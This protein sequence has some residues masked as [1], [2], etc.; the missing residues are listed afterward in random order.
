MGRKVLITG[1]AGFIA[2]HVADAHLAAG[3]RVTIL[4]DLSSGRRENI[5]KGAE[6]VHGDIRS[7]EARALLAS[8]GFNVL[9]HHAAQI[10]VRHSVADPVADSGINIVGLLNLLEGARAGGVRRVVFASSG[11]VVYGEKGRLPMVETETKLPVSPYGGAKLASEYYLAIYTALYG[12]ETVALRYSN[13]YGPRQRADGE[14]GVVAIFGR[15]LL[16]GQP[17]T[18]FGDGQQTRDM[19]FV[20]DVAEANVAASNWP[21]AP[22]ESVDTRAFNI[23]TGVETSVNRLAEL[24]AAAA[25]RKLDAR[26]APARAGELSRSVLSV[27]KAGR[28]LGW[29]P[30][31]PLSEG[32]RATM[33]YLAEQD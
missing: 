7:A 23:G 5:P 32:L 21:V 17:I 19:V 24:L 22:L 1:G 10:D 29:K 12:M 18:I 15:R 27:E 9:N 2:S 31:T 28:V 20:K 11:G 4:D 30:R 14:A 6:F 25:G 13:V 26:P 16:A 8:G 3:D 33:R